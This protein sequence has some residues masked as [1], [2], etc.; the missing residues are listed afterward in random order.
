MNAQCNS[1]GGFRNPINCPACTTLICEN[2]RTNHDSVCAETIK[3]KRSGFGA[4][5]RQAA[6]DSLVQSNAM[7]D[8]FIATVEA[9]GLQVD[10][11]AFAVLAGESNASTPPLVDAKVEGYV[12]WVS[13]YP[14]PPDASV[15]SISPVENT[16][17]VESSIE[18]PVPVVTEV[19]GEAVGTS[20]A[21]SNAIVNFVTADASVSTQV[22]APSPNPPEILGSDLT[23]EEK[24]EPSS[25]AAGDGQP[26]PKLT[27]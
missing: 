24:T 27:S 16:L 12:D 21:P 11:A 4:T 2:C 17:A 10:P 7:V 26:E 9:E 22:V 1:C 18:N 3:Q 20:P 13:V 6:V 19:L 25:T 15:T 14:A 8:A 23:Q 5:V